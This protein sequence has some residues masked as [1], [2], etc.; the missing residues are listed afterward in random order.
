V[1][2]CGYAIVWASVAGS[3]AVAG[4]VPA[5]Q[6][7]L[8]WSGGG[9]V[10]PAASGSWPWLSGPHWWARCAWP[11]L[12]ATV[13]SPMIACLFGWGGGGEDDGAGKMPYKDWPQRF[14]MD[15]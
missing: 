12:Q 2:S 1:N 5:R 3:R 13:G 14:G 6:P 4:T 7:Y 9:R 8:L 10:V 11:T 15:W